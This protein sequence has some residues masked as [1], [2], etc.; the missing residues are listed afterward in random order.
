M[1]RF[2]VGDLHG[3]FDLF[4]EKMKEI[5]FNKETDIM[6]SVG[7]LI[8]RGPDSMK[9]LRLLKEPWFHAVRGNHE[10]LMISVILD[11]SGLWDQ[12]PGDGLWVQNG[13]GWYLTVDKE[14]LK[15][16]AVLASQL[17][18]AITIDEKIGVCHAEP[19][20]LDWNDAIGEPSSYHKEKMIWGRNRVYRDLVTENIDITYHGHTILKEKTTRG[21]AVFI[22]TGAYFYNNLTV[23]EI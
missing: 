22:D 17:P 6:Y 13:G 16:L 4:E 19:P 11:N 10:D 1:R 7:D 15:E 21:N 9:C 5:E 8:D 12:N 20:T 18:Y 2:I 3:R 14:E 23:V